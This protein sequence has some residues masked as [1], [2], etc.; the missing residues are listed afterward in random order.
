MVGKITYEQNIAKVSRCFQSRQIVPRPKDQGEENLQIWLK[1]R[2]HGKADKAKEQELFKSVCLSTPSAISI[3]CWFPRQHIQPHLYRDPDPI[4]NYLVDISTWV[5][6]F[7]LNMFKTKIIIFL[8]PLNLY[9]NLCHTLIIIPLNF[10]QA[11]Q[12]LQVCTF[13]GVWCQ[14]TVIMC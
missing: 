2:P 8:C 3:E 5:Q 7:K 9:V 11:T 6:P 10:N 12:H 1:H 14:T 4:S 13:R